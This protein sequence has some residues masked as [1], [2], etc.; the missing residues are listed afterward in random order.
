MQSNLDGL[1]SNDLKLL[2]RKIEGNEEENLRKV[3]YQHTL[4]G[5]VLVIHIGLLR[6]KPL[7]ES[8]VK[9]KSSITKTKINTTINLRISKL[10]PEQSICLYTFIKGGD[11]PCPLNYT[12]TNVVQ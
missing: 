3:I 4:R 1:L 11:F 8:Y 10:Y 5:K 7:D 12:D 6:R 9:E 2:G